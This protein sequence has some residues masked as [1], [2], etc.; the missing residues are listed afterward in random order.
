MMQLSL[1]DRLI[2]SNQFKILQLLD[3]K[4]KQ[5]YEE[6]IA[7]VEKGFQ[8]DY[9]RL[10]EWMYE[11]LPEHISKEVYSILE[12]YRTITFAYER[13]TSEEQARI[14]SDKLK[15]RGFDGNNEVQHRSYCLFLLKDRDLY[16]ELH[17]NTDYNTHHPILG[18]YR[19]M[20]EQWNSIGE[21]RELNVQEIEQ[22]LTA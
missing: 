12:L 4:N 18:K 6:S 1:K 2:L 14:P 16:K 11:E 13:L 20:L 9:D 3:P 15:F 10:V 22:I 8:Q 19:M 17:H 21:K 7:I 5:D